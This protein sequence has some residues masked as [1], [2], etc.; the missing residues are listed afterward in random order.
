MWLPKAHVEAPVAGSIVLAGILLKLGSYGLYIFL[1]LF[2]HYFLFTYLFISVVGGVVCSLVCV[3]QWDTK[4]LIAYSSV[5]HIG[6]VRVGF[7][8]GSELGY[9]RALIIMIAH[10]LCSPLL[11]GI[12][13]YFYSNS[14]SRL[15]VHSRG[16]MTA[17]IVALVF[18]VLL[19]IN[20]GV[21]PFLNVWTEVMFFVVMLNIM[22]S[23]MP[24]L[25]CL[26]FFAFLYNILIYVSLVHSKEMATSASPF[27]PWYY[28][29]SIRLSLL[30]SANLRFCIV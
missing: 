27:S 13:F 6:V 21:P 18:F 1:P 3:R 2:S 25:I 29:S 5:V 17:P 14:R 8:S 4:G 7:L 16:V 26:A 28:I 19:A 22:I 15:L 23:R 20:M 11:F 10:G 24:F 9:S 12:A 30:V